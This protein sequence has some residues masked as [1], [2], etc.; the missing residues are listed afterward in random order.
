[1]KKNIVILFFLLNCPIFAGITYPYSIEYFDFFECGKLYLSTSKNQNNPEQNTA[2]NEP[3]FYFVKSNWLMDNETVYS[4][5]GFNRSNSKGENIG[6]A[7]IVDATYFQNKLFLLLKEN[8]NLTIATFDSTVSQKNKIV[9]NSNELLMNLSVSHSAYSMKNIR[10]ISNKNSD[11]LF[12]LNNEKLYAVGAYAIR[13]EKMGV[14]NTP[15]QLIAENVID[16]KFFTNNNNYEFAYIVDKR[17]YGLIYFLDKQ[18]NSHYVARVPITDKTSIFPLQNFLITANST[19]NFSDVLLSVI[20]IYSKN[21]LASEWLKINQNLLD[22]ENFSDNIFALTSEKNNYKLK[23]IPALSLNNENEWQTVNLPENLY[24]P[25]KLVVLGD[26][27]Y[28]FF[29]NALVVYDSELNEIIFDYYDF[30][31]F[32]GDDLEVM[33]YENYL[34]LSSSNGSLILRKDANSLW[35]INRQILTT[36]KYAVPI[37]LIL[38]IIFILRNYRNQKRLF[39]AIIELPSFGFVFFINRVGKLVK[40]N[41]GGKQI[42]DISDNIPL[43]KQ[44]AY[45]CKT[46]MTKP[47]VEI[48]ER[49]LVE[50]LSFQQKINIIAENTPREW[51][52]SLMPL[53]NIAGRFSG[54]ILTGIDITEELERRMLTNWSQLA[55][56]MQ[57]NLSTI[58]LNAEQMHINSENDLKIRNKIIQQVTILI[59]RVRDIVTVGRD[60]KLETSTVNSVDFCNEIRSE[61]DDNIFSQVQ[62]AMN[63]IDFNFICDKPKLLRAVRNAVENGIKAMK[64]K[65]GTITISCR[66]DIHHIMISV[67]D[68]GMGMDEN[69]KNKIFTPF[70]STARKE[71]GYG[72]GTMIMQRVAELHGGKLLIES[73]LNIGTEMTFQIPDLARKRV[74]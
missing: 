70:Y 7:F 3:L 30:S 63:L 52:C 35:F 17:E 15:L 36:Y 56:D 10:L 9:L 21:I 28:I 27:I 57:T 61:F 40:L 71:G 8:N 34:I 55:H 60:D 25:I 49:G 47:I 23:K 54:I 48:V 20:D 12:L 29:H 33:K 16:C 19:G 1:M 37:I 74:G 67:K 11:K 32:S 72:I 53:R 14:C 13:P 50:R 44:I 45:Y 2:D 26:L 51:L 18:S 64:N 6:N 59:Q 73:K 68:T 5:K 39:D 62:F 43:G 65:G 41:E 46:D 58:R 66:K 31:N 24:S 42:L 4:W 22:I 38:T 69:T